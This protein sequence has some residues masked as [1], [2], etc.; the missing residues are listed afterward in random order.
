MILPASGHRAMGIVTGR[1]PT[2]AGGD[3]KAHR[4]DN[5]IPMM[6]GLFLSR[7]RSPSPNDFA[8]QRYWVSIRRRDLVQPSYIHHRSALPFITYGP[9]N[10]KNGERKQCRLI[11]PVHSTLFVEF[12]EFPVDYLFIF[13]TQWV[14]LSLAL[15]FVFYLTSR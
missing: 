6:T 15:D 4:L 10:R 11:G 12:V 8:L 5:I 13:C 14:H 7:N 9:P 2:R 3:R 1:Y